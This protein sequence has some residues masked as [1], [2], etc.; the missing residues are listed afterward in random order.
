MKC[1]H[2][3]D[4]NLTDTKF[5]RHCGIAFGDT[6]AGSLQEARVVSARR[7]D[8]DALRAL[9]MVLGIALHAALTFS[10][11][12][13]PVQDSQQNDSF[14]LAVSAIHGFRMPV[15]FLM[16][17]FFTAMLWRNRGVR[18]LITHRLKRVGL[19]LVL[20]MITI[21][22]LMN[23]S[24]LAVLAL[25]EIVSEIGFG[26]SD[27]DSGKSKSLDVYEENIIRPIISGDIGKVQML[28][29]KG[30]INWKFKDDKFGVTLLSWATLSGKKDMVELLIQSGAD[31]NAKS[32]DGTTALHGAAFLGQTEIVELF[33]KNKADLNIVNDK[34]ETPLDSA[35]HGWD[36][37]QGIMQIVGGI[38]QMEIDLDRAKAGRP[39]IVD[40]LKENGGRSGE[41]F[42]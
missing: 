2:C 41:E 32:R 10:E 7:Y 35:A 22:P 26:S 1:T 23:C 30:K 6:D 42:R 18:S 14:G 38:L 12:G 34:G 24:W 25:P 21:V 33:I 37:I 39:K 31:V 19:P 27:V 15:F 40:L 3:G 5:C 36:E 29:D 20:A 9:A 17:G 16:S 28:L 8:F 4:E 11:T 13:W